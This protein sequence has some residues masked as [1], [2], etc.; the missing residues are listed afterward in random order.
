MSK[1]PMQ[2]VKLVF[3]ADSTGRRGKGFTKDYTF[4]AVVNKDGDGI[5]IRKWGRTGAEGQIKVTK[6]AD[7]EHLQHTLMQEQ[8][9]RGAR[10]Y[11]LDQSKETDNILSATEL[12]MFLGR[13]V[14]PRTGADNLKHL[15]PDFDTTGIKD[16]REK[17]AVKHPDGSVTYEYLPKLDTKALK[18]REE[19]AE[20]LA[21]EKRREDNQHM[22]ETNPTWGM[23]G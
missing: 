10:D 16:P 12:K 5:L 1:Y 15:D 8:K 14:W 20:Q 3:R 17:V 11:Y 2:A 4:Y 23:F 6:H 21:R 18:K 19:V 13:M 22:M 9:Q 7:E